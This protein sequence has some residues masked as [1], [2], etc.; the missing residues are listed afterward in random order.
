[1]YQMS[2]MIIPG[3]I[4][5]NMGCGLEKGDVL[6]DSEGLDNMRHLGEVIDWLGKAT[7]PVRD[8]YPVPKR[9]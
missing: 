8:A 2:Q 5:W 7:A 3:S 1:M 9:R 6:G 4:Y